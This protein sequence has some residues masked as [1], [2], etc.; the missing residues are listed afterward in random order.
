MMGCLPWILLFDTLDTVLNLLAENDQPQQQPQQR[1]HHVS[2]PRR[3]ELDW[4]VPSPGTTQGL[5]CVEH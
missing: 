4:S 2:A 1:G 3:G 5:D